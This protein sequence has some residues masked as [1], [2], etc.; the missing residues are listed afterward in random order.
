V[1]RSLSPTQLAGI[2]VVMQD[3]VEEDLARGIAPDTQLDCDACRWSRPM[4]GFIRYGCY[5]LCN[6]CATAYEVAQAQ[7]E[8]DSPGQFLRDVYRG[9][10]GLVALPATPGG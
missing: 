6:R 8:V 3:F 2:P 7:G 5:Q 1:A 10:R 4:P 9:D